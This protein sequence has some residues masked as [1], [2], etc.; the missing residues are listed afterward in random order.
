MAGAAPPGLPP[1]GPVARRTS[2]STANDAANDSM[3]KLGSRKAEAVPRVNVMK[4]SVF[5]KEHHGDGIEDGDLRHA[6]AINTIP[7]QSR[8]G[9]RRKLQPDQE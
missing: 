4:K 6:R 2:A 5:A 7:L 3:R 1:G 9:K 8:P